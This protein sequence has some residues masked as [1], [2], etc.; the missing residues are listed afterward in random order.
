MKRFT[1]AALAP[2]VSV[3]GMISSVREMTWSFCRALNTLGVQVFAAIAGAAAC[4]WTCSFANAVSEV[5]HSGDAAAPTAA[6]LS[7]RS[8]SRRFIAFPV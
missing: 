4:V 5:T 6:V 7:C 8:A 1:S 2:G 3:A